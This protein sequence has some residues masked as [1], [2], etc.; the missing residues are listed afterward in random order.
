MISINIR[1]MA[2]L[3]MPIAGSPAYRPSTRSSSRISGQN[4][5]YGV[6]RLQYWQQTTKQK[7][8]KA[9]AFLLSASTK[10][11]SF[12]HPINLGGSVQRRATLLTYLTV[13]PELA[14]TK[15]PVCYQIPVPALMG[16]GAHSIPS[17]EQHKAIEV[18][19]KRQRKT[20]HRQHKVLLLGNGDAGK[21][22]FCK[23]V[24]ILHGVPTDNSLYIDALRRNCL[25]SFADAVALWYV[26]FPTFTESAQ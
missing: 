10:I 4:Y 18:S 19:I 11:I 2:K 1:R 5:T 20:M 15:L 13:P 24:A 26:F 3:P 21:S 12:I 16:C 14:T 25:S 6:W 8:A 17:S 9:V 7:I 23:Q 22:T